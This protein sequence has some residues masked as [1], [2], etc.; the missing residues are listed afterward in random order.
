ML[1]YIMEHKL[2]GWVNVYHAWLK[3]IESWQVTS[4]CPIMLSSLHLRLLETACTVQLVSLLLLG[5][6]TL[7]SRWFEVHDINNKLLLHVE[8]YCKHILVF[9]P[10]LLTVYDTH[11][12][13]RYPFESLSV[14]Y[15]FTLYVCILWSY[16]IL[17]LTCPLMS[18]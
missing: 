2:S 3:N 18:W 8:Y 1:N 9:L 14:G 5:D 15:G 11:K 4:L 17:I 6:N 13:D 10:Y 7:V 16:S 12:N